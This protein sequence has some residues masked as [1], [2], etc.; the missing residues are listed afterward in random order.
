MDDR[1]F[2][3]LLDRLDLSWQGYRKVR[4][5][6][7]KR[8]SRHMQR[9]GCRNLEEYFDI[10]DGSPEILR[11]VELLMTVSISRFFRDRYLWQA[12]EEEIIPDVI[13]RYSEEINVWSAGC[14][15]GQEAYSFKILWNILESKLDRLPQLRLWG[16]D[17]NP[18]YL[19]K[20]MEGVY[21]G[22]T[23]KEVSEDIKTT[24]FRASEDRSLYFIAD[25]L[26]KGIIWETYDLI[27]EPPPAKKFQ[28]IFLRNNLL[29][30]YRQEIKESVFLKVM[31]S[32]AGGGFLIIGTH[33]KLPIQPRF[34][35]QFR[36][37]SYIFQKI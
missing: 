37:Y 17:I 7:K 24:C 13:E 28:I 5:G 18:D 4:K 22:S 11:E 12:L 20:A 30:Y 2:S 33:E 35:S 15:Q 23:L 9:L 34:L 21:I 29:T 31:D 6:V 14:A 26:K 19:S 3:Q 32:L 16:T 25:H 8:I 36:R 27:K 1:Q 10:L